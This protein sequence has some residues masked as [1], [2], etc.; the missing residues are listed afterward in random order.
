[1]CEI[2]KRISKWLIINIFILSF[3][4]ISI[5][6]TFGQTTTISFIQ[7]LP[8]S[9]SIKNTSKWLNLK[10][11]NRYQQGSLKLEYSNPNYKFDRRMYDPAR[12]MPRDPFKID[13]RSGS[14][15][16]PRMVRD[17][18]AHIMNRPKDSAFV[19][20]LGAAFLAAKLA[21]QYLII[22]DKITITVE[23]ILNSSDNKELLKILWLDNP[24]TLSQLFKDHSIRKKYSMYILENKINILVDNKLVKQKLIE[25]DETLYFPAITNQKYIEIVEEGLP[26]SS[27]TETDKNKL[28]NLLIWAKSGKE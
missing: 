19:P 4:L 3:F 8:D 28:K 14:Y 6:I 16:V 22:K 23:N 10:N 26:Y 27:M 7:Q 9:T 24:K 2:D 11:W 25:N 18:L 13:L 5:N 21:A 15:Y 17:E 20:V 12:V 1:M